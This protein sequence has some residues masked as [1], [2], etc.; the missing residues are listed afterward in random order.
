MDHLDDIDAPEFAM[1]RDGSRAALLALNPHFYYDPD[2]NYGNEIIPHGHWI[3]VE[4]AV[5]SFGWD[6]VEK[7]PDV[8]RM[9]SQM[10]RATGE[11]IKRS[12]LP[13]R[14]PKDPE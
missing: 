12:V 4:L 2:T 8:Q 13:Y 6:E 7:S 1:S 3:T 10:P 9:L 5:R 14:S 11:F